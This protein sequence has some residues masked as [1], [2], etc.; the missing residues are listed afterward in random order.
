MTNQEIVHATL[1]FAAPTDRVFALLAD[2]TTHAAIDGTGWVQG[3]VD[4]APLT[5]EGQIFRMGMF[6]AGHPE[7]HYQTV[8]KVAV[9]EAPRAIGWLTGQ[10]LG[11][12]SFEFGG[13]LWRYD[14][15][16]LGSA[17]TEVT[18]SY[19]WSGVPQYT[20]DRGIPFPP[21]GPEHL[22]NS[23]RHLATLA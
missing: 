7:G 19:D 3:S 22:I 10:E 6:H 1:T 13:W 17:E 4:Q 18:L 21:F 8:N 23:L 2:P 11:D 12:G 20:R 14:L 16:P 15:A 9:F 5:Q